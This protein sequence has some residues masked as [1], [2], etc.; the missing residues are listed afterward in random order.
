MAVIYDI[1][2]GVS[3]RRGLPQL[4]SGILVGFGECCECFFSDRASLHRLR[5]DGIPRTRN[6]AITTQAI[7]LGLGMIQ[8]YDEQT[9]SNHNLDLVAAIHRLS[10]PSSLFEREHRR[11]SREAEHSTAVF[12]QRPDATQPLPFPTPES[13]QD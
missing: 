6:E 9:P 5:D 2:A 10:Q 7:R 8:R 11:K 4:W 13:L 12:I 3:F 1:D